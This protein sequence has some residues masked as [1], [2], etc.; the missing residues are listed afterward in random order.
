M[1]V[2]SRRF[3]GALYHPRRRKTTA[4]RLVVTEGPAIRGRPKEGEKVLRDHDK[5]HGRAIDRRPPLVSELASHADGWRDG[6]RERPRIPRWLS[7][8]AVEL[9][10]MRTLVCAAPVMGTVC[11]A[12]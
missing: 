9:R 4:G 1:E 5:K 10:S 3:M 8:K 12:V 2:R 11:R 7:R 6:E